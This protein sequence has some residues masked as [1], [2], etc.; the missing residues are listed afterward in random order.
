MQQLLGLEPCLRFGDKVTKSNMF[1]ISS[2]NN[3]ERVHE[4]EHLQI[5][6]ELGD[7]IIPGQDT[8]G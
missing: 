8:S 6:V 2:I 3:L 5:Q 1:N 4:L 7:M